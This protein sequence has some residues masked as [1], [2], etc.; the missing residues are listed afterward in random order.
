MSF[1]SSNGSRSSVRLRCPSSSCIQSKAENAAAVPPTCLSGDAVLRQ[2]CF[3]EVARKDGP[4]V[5]ETSTPMLMSH[6]MLI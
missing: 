6:Q 4:L 5:Q 1:P 2:V 3:A